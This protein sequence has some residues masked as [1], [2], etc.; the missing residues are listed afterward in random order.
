MNRIYFA[1]L[2]RII[3]CA[4]LPALLCQYFIAMFFVFAP[5]PS[6]VPPPA[7]VV[8]PPP[9][10][11]QP[12][13]SQEFHFCDSCHVVPTTIPVAHLCHNCTT[14][15]PTPRKITI[16]KQFT[17]PIA[18]PPRLTDKQIQS[19]HISNSWGMWPMRF[20]FGC[21]RPRSYCNSVFIFLFST[22]TPLPILSF[23]LD[24]IVT[25]LLSL[26]VWGCVLS[27][28]RLTSRA[29][30]RD[31]DDIQ[32]ELEN[33]RKVSAN[34]DAMRPNTMFSPPVPIFP[35][36]HRSNHAPPLGDNTM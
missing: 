1:A 28:I 17:P 18:G 12:Y 2:L 30:R 7:P 22:L 35:L 14:T 29:A 21:G 8:C 11:T 23:S 4:I 24:T 10:T 13:L 25:I 32:T 3:I 15:P 34:A 6:P 9:V 5:S 16:P 31:W 36:T 20:F 27:Y 26:L 19:D 33:N